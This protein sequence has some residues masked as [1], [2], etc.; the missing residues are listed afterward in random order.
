MKLPF[1]F[2]GFA[3]FSLVAWCRLSELSWLLILSLGRRW[4]WRR[5][6]RGTAVPARAAAAGTGSAVGHGHR[7]WHRQSRVA[8][9]IHFSFI[10][11]KMVASWRGTAR[12]E[13]QRLFGLRPRQ[14]HHLRRRHC[15]CRHVAAACAWHLVLALGCSLVSL[16]LDFMVNTPATSTSTGTHTHTH[17]YTHTH[18]EIPS[19][20]WTWTHSHVHTH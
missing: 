10:R 6:R 9:V 19:Y 17:S 15:R 3:S 1:G 8:L 13:A 12:C 11:Y 14:R 20:T 16:W 5:R 4:R 18:T 7:H 2:V